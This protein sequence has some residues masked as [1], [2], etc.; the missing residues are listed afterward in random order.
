MK[1]IERDEEEFF[2]VLF[3]KK[4]IYSNPLVKSKFDYCWW[5]F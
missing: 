3:L 4:Y 5:M 1:Y 2:K